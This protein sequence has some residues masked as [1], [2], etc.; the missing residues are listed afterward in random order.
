MKNRNVDWNRKCGTFNPRGRGT[1]A[2]CYIHQNLNLRVNWLWFSR[3]IVPGW[4]LHIS[5]IPRLCHP[6]FVSFIFCSF[7][8]K[9]NCFYINKETPK[10][11]F[12]QHAKNNEHEEVQKGTSRLFLGTTSHEKYFLFFFEFW[13]VSLFTW[14]VHCQAW[15]TYTADIKIV[16]NPEEPIGQQKRNMQKSMQC[17]IS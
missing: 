11:T 16:L 14:H 8:P 3:V 6:L 15:C 4:F 12:C 5:Y 9:E 1:L 13:C 10:S 2:T 17:V 7:S